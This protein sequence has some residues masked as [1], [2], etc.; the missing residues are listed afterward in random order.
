M[1][2]MLW[3]VGGYQDLEHGLSMDWEVDFPINPSSRACC[4][5]QNGTRK[6]ELLNL[7]LL[8]DSLWNKSGTNCTLICMHQDSIVGLQLAFPCQGR[9]K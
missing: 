6:K 7:I 3:W 5:N 2:S 8:K 1:T 4:V 9:E